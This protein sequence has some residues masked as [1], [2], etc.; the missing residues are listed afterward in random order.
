MQHFIVIWISR[1]VCWCWNKWSQIIFITL[2]IFVLSPFLGWNCPQYTAHVRD[3]RF[4]WIFRVYY[5]REP[6]ACLLSC[7]QGICWEKKNEKEGNWKRGGRFFFKTRLKQDF[8]NKQL[9]QNQGYEVVLTPL[10]LFYEAA[11]E[12]IYIFRLF[13]NLCVWLYCCCKIYGF[14]PK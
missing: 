6:G 8:F 4:S 5:S 3:L 12:S 10:N 7:K 11:I 9:W 1:I 2:H 14:L 13:R